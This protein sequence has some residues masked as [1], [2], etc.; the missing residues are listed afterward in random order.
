MIDFE[1]PAD[2]AALRDEIAAVVAVDHPWARRERPVHARELTREPYLTREQGSGT[3]QAFDRAMQGL[4]PQLNIVLEL[5]HTEAI[6]RAVEAGMGIS[7]LSRIS[8]VDAFARKSLV[9]LAV[10]HRDFSRRLYVALHKHKYSSPS[11]VQWLQLCEVS[12]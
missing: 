2:L 9:P 5:E 11:V 10:P 12:I 1:I 6:K 3:R 7:C 8:L 4:L